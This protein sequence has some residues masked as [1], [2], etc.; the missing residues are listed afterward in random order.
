MLF[1]QNSHLSPDYK[2]LM[3]RSSGQLM[4]NKK[5]TTRK[6]L[7]PPKVCK[8][9]FQRAAQMLSHHN[10]IKNDT[11]VFALIPETEDLRKSHRLL[12]ELVEQFLKEHFGNCKRPLNYFK[13]LLEA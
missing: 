2:C 11:E 12:T 3:E 6:L 4:N 13:R 8:P 10:L 5:I 9:E 1:E 7:K